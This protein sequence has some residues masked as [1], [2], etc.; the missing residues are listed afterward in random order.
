M[1]VTLQTY[2]RQFLDSGKTWDIRLRI[3]CFSYRFYRPT[4]DFGLRTWDFGLQTLDFGLRTYFRLETSDFTLTV[5][6]RTDVGLQSSDRHRAVFRLRTDFRQT[7]D[8]LQMTDFRLL[9]QTLD[10]R[11]TSNIRRRILNFGL[12][13]FD[14]GFR[15]GQHILDFGQTS[16]F[17]FQSS[18]LRTDFGLQ[19]SD[20]G[21]WTSNRLWISSFGQISD[22]GLWTSI[23]EL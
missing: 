12:R 10:F 16:D 21:L 8:I 22:L 19:I 2:F 11:Q 15:R 1:Y 3:F 6:F 9:L 20:F 5:R 4:P 18:D 13:I 7:S 14:F 17:K 23:F